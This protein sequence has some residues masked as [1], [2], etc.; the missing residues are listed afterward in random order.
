MTV[1]ATWLFTLLTLLCWVGV[2][3]VALTDRGKAAVARPGVAV[4][5]AASVTGTATL[6]SLYLS[7][8]AGYV[9]CE[10]CWVQRIFMYSLAVITTTAVLRRRDDVFTYAV[11][12][13][14]LGLLTS[15][16][17]VIVQRAPA[18]GVTCDPNNPCSAIWVERLGF[19]TIPVM[20]GT[21]FLV[22]LVLGV[23]LWGQRR[24]DVSATR[25]GETTTTPTPAH[26][27]EEQ[28]L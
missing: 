20:A 23:A 4:G 5:I 24:S 15:I 7:E 19:I 28:A 16:W 25:S 18:A 11:P 2:L 9:P 12:L 8:V 10:L 3:V 1:A 21:A 14:A 27:L 6:G 22:V 26:P 13:A 17:H